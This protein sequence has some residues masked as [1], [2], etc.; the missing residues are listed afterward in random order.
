MERRTEGSIQPHI[1]E[2]GRASLALSCP[3]GGDTVHG[4]VLPFVPSE[5][6]KNLVHGSELR[7]SEP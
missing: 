6:S 1:S 4:S 3:E 5:F 7:G 2:E